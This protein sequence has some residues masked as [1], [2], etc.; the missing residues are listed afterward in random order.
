MQNWYTSISPQ[1]QSSCNQRRLINEFETVSNC[2]QF[3]KIEVNTVCCKWHR[4]DSCRSFV[5][6]G[7]LCQ[8]P[9]QLKWHLGRIP[10]RVWS[11]KCASG[12]IDRKSHRV[13]LSFDWAVFCLCANL[14]YKP[15]WGHR[16]SWLKLFSFLGLIL[17]SETQRVGKLVNL[18]RYSTSFFFN[19][20]LLWDG[21]QNRNMLAQ[22]SW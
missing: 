20:I 19:Q 16:L 6:L 18:S 5:H 3:S 14:D 11:G 10:S 15:E 8:V 9:N 4:N 22:T 7:C 2:L 17:S 1:V 13:E 21:N 12:F